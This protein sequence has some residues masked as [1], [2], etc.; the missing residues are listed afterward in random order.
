VDPSYGSD[1]AELYHH[2][3]WWRAREAILLR[4][5]AALPLPPAERAEI[6]DVGCGNGL[7][8]PEL[9]RFGRPT[10]IEVERALVRDDAPLREC[11]RHE[12]L[13]SP[14]WE[15]RAFDLV[16]AL[17]VVEHI[18]DDAA[19]VARLAARVRPGGFLLATV[20]A[21]PS[22]W[23]AHD[24]RNHHQR[25]YRRAGF[26]AL[27]APHGAL[28]TVRHLFPSLFVAKWLVA[29]VN[30]GPAAAIDQTALPGP[31]VSR[32]LAALL[33]AEDR[34]LGPLR[35]PFGSSLLAVLR[36]SG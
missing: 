13:E 3:W 35:L 27:L 26:E 7:F 21:F 9:A 28:V 10:G 14:Y 22:L 23:D 32:S 20:P 24:E 25:R 12:P 36:V 11:I 30:R 17:D 4:E 1:Y 8:L 5:I 29:R 18:A 19:F 16:L 2:H 6:L 34:V 33:R 31:A 15:G